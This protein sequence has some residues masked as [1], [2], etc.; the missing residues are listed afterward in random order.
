MLSRKWRTKLRISARLPG[1][2]EN[3]S[4]LFFISDRIT[5]A[6]VRIASRFDHRKMRAAERAWRA[7]EIFG[8]RRLP[9]CSVRQLAGHVLIK[10]EDFRARRNAASCRE[11]HAGSVRSP[12]PKTR[13]PRWTQTKSEFPFRTDRKSTRLNSSHI[14]ISYAVF[15][16]KK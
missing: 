13:R 4:F 9:A 1:W 15:C 16:L 10:R 12:E 3:S 2:L 11:L 6:R 5:L 14:T 7:T 8:E